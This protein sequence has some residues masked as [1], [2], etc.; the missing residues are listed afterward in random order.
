NSS[1]DWSYQLQTVYNDSFAQLNW[2]Q[3][4]QR[5]YTLW[6]KQSE[7]SSIES[8]LENQSEQLTNNIASYNMSLHHKFQINNYSDWSEQ[9]R[10]DYVLRGDYSF[11]TY[12]KKGLD[13]RLEILDYNRANNEDNIVINI[14]N[15]FGELVDTIRVNDDGYSTTGVAPIPKRYI[16]IHN[17]QLTE[18]VY[19]VEFLAGYDIFTTSI[20][21]KHRYLT[22]NKILY[23]ANST[24]YRDGNPIIPIKE[25][26]LI[27]NS[28]TLEFSTSHP[29]GL[30]TVTVNNTSL[31]IKEL[32]RKYS[33]KKLSGL[34]KLIIPKSDMM[35]SGNGLFAFDWSMFFEPN[36]NNLEIINN[37]SNFSYFIAAYIP[38]IIINNIASG[39]VNFSL[40]RAAIEQ[41][42]LRFIIA[43]PGSSQE[44]PL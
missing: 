7:F 25:N 24:E 9:R 8:F 31:T 38:P 5:G 33:L 17:D 14:K 15:E 35:I 19:Q 6:Q 29:A 11:Y 12:I 32:Q 44:N 1:N 37:N 10:F 40:D 22:F 21:T 23:L 2:S 41:N 26:K 34:S 20:E 4:T 42:K 43:C 36:I 27:T 3:I 30:Q 28:T 16:N 39:S 18:G 13:Y